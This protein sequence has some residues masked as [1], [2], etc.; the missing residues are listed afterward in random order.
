MCLHMRLVKSSDFYTVKVRGYITSLHLDV[1]DLL[2]QPI[3]G[4]APTSIYRYLYAT[5]DFRSGDP[6]SFSLIHN[7]LGFT[8]DQIAIA[9]NRLEGLGL[10]RSFLNARPEFNEFVLELYA[11]KDPA[12]FSNDKI[13]MHLL[14]DILGPRHTQELLSIFMLDQKTINQEE[15]TADFASIYGPQVQDM[16]PEDF[17]EGQTLQNK[18][19]KIKIAF[20]EVLFLNLLTKIR[21]ILPNALSKN[22]VNMLIQ[23][24]GLYDLTEEALANLVGD[25]YNAS[26]P[27]GHRVDISAMQSSLQEIIKFP[28]ISKTFRRPVQKISGESEMIKNI[29]EMETKGPIDYLISLNKGTKIAPADQK[30][31][32]DLAFDYNLTPPVINALIF[33]TLKHNDNQL[34]RA[35]MEKN[36]SLLV[37]SKAKNALDAL[38]V[39]ERPPVKKERRSR[40]KAEKKVEPKEEA[41]N[42]NDLEDDIWDEIKDL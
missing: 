13:F 41:I 4:F 16:K 10:V 11:P 37:R 34:I 38:D 22:E 31:L 32:N 30:I 18:V 28:V 39:L 24:A 19:G 23:V 36:A 29:N 5:R 8:Y 42:A 27:F 3:I 25:Y 35:L 26:E 15:T 12:E 20:D 1:L 6:L 14:N 21:K 33:Y 2:Y 7:H 17:Y 40:V 9:I